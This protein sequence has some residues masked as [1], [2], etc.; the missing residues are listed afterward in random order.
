M[1]ITHHAVTAFVE[2]GSSGSEE[3]EGEGEGEGKGK[4]GDCGLR[5]HCPRNTG[6]MDMSVS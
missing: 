5:H 2:S 6:A 1:G 4:G 3:G